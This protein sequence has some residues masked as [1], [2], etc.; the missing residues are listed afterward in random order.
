MNI[1]KHFPHLILMVMVSSAFQS[2][3]NRDASRE[4]PLL[5][6]AGVWAENVRD[7]MT[8]RQ[9][10]GQLVMAT[11]TWESDIPFPGDAYGSPSQQQKQHMRRMITEF[12]AGSVII[13]N[14]GRAESMAQFNGQ[15]QEWSVQSN[16]GVPL[17]ISAD[18][19]YGVAQRIPEEATVFPRQMGIAATGDPVAAYEQGRITAIEALAT[20]FNWSYSPVSD[21]NVNPGNPVIGVRSFGE[22]YPLVSELSRAMIR[23]SQEHGVIATPKHF[24]GHGDTDFDS[25][26]DLSMVTYDMEMLR[27]VHLP[28]F[29][30]AFDAGA[31]AVMTAHVIIEAI[32]PTVPA[33]LSPKVL[34]GLLRKEMGFEGVIVTD[35]MSMK[36][37]DDHWGAGDAAVMA[38]KAGADIIMA[39]GTEQQQAETFHALYQALR[40]GE[41]SEERLNESVYR[42][43]RIKHKYGL[44][45]HFI[46][47]DPARALKVT[48]DPENRRI[49][50]DIAARSIT[51]VRNRETL[52][53]D[54]DEELTTLVA[55]VAYTEELAE[56][57][58]QVGG[59]EVV[60]WN[61]GDV[62][63]DHNPTPEAIL[64]AI[65]K[66]GDADR[67][68]LFTYSAGELPEGQARLAEALSIMG[69]PMTVVALGL[70]YDLQEMQ[71]VPA[72]V[73]TYSLDRWPAATPTPV[74][75]EAVV[76]ML[77][78]EQPGG[79]LPVTL[80][81][82]YTVG[83]G[84]RY[85]TGTVQN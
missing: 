34:T 23:G 60:V 77:F 44:H 13:Y 83:H 81:R 12:H 53:F 51:L 50:R 15:L 45:H 30:A 36:A 78:G 6:D 63:G 41:I 24:P 29:Q 49:A 65:R 18:M 27:E 48:T 59:G 70:P 43:L 82:D 54:V 71:T 72:F 3:C 7:S 19:E 25:H 21:V 5:L 74:V 58:R 75:W 17:F 1:H 85:G 69:K 73:A 46:P 38:V 16:A 42:I 10:I 31:D 14:W 26:Y 64:E 76:T 11:T 32:D 9:K 37:I 39:T 33:T 22:Q 35:A 68:I 20:G 62:P 40:D 79:T 55:G 2:G 8:D 56:L 66:A 47:P 80:G 52:P 67:I 61:F 57:V 28:P 4:D 84:L